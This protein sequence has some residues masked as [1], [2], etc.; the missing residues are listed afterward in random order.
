MSSGNVI[1][2]SG[3]QIIIDRAF[4]GTVSY[5][6]PSQVKF[7]IDSATPVSSDTDLDN[8]IPISNG[9]IIGDCSEKFDALFSGTMSTTNTTVYKEGAG[10]TDNVSQN[11]F[12]SGTNTTSQWY[13]GTINTAGVNTNKF[14]CWLYILNSAT[15]NMLDS[16]GTATRIFIGSDTTNYYH[17]DK[18]ATQLSTGWNWLSSGTQI[19][20]LSMSGSVS[21]TLSTFGLFMYRG[22]GTTEWGSGSVVVDLFRQWSSTDELLDYDT[23]YPTVNTTTLVAEHRITLPTT[24]AN[25]FDLDSMGNFNSDTTPKISG[26]S[27]FTSESKSTTDRFIFVV[28]NILE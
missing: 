1:T 3:K 2:Q 16:S 19:T 17:F 26:K 15:L 22:S 4:S 9:T 13:S 20:A 18:T 5:S 6:V 8:V 11:L 12:T 7:G 25:G 10:T 14:G 28:Q 24:S 21:G 23:G 27:V